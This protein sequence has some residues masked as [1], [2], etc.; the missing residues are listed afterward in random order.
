[1]AYFIAI[2]T[3]EFETQDGFHFFGGLKG[4]FLF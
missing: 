1:V 4:Q 2:R 3:K